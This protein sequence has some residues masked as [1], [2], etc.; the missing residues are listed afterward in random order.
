MKFDYTELIQALITLVSVV[1]TGFLVPLLKQRLSAE[2]RAKLLEY[3]RIGVAAAEQIYGS[4][5]GQKKMNYVIDFLETKGFTFDLNEVEA[6][7][8]SEVYKLTQAAQTT[9]TLEGEP[10]ETVEG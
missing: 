10:L 6:M 4:K 3:V 8:E 1:I 9:V 5:A 7:I 2:K